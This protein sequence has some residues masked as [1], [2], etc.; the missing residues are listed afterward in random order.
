MNQAKQTIAVD[1]DDVLASINETMRQ[2]INKYYGHNHTEA[3]YNRDGEYWGYWE[4][5]WQISDEESK[6]R[7]QAFITS[8]EFLDV[9]THDAALDVINRLKRK[10][11]LVIVTARED[12]RIE[13][14]HK[15]LDQNF[16][17][18]FKRVEFTPVW[19]KDKKT[20][21]A[22]ICK[23]IGAGYLIDDN[24]EHCNLAAQEGIQALLFGE[25]GWNRSQE[26][27]KRVKRVKDWHAVAEYFSV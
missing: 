8:K 5:I 19:S 7:Y 6:E 23:V 26:L 10:Y 22:K 1:I 15:W 25:Y 4:K 3:D 2:F 20:S 11:D 21:K 24:V 14:T 13:G 18:I 16:P 27:H 9:N 12:S 17:N